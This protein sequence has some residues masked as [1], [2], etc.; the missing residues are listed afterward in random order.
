MMGL[1]SSGIITA[2]PPNNFAN[3]LWCYLIVLSKH[4]RCC[5]GIKGSF[6]SCKILRGYFHNVVTSSH[7]DSILH[8][9]LLCPRVK[10]TDTMPQETRWGMQDTQSLVRGSMR[11]RIRKDMGVEPLLVN[12]KHAISCGNIPCSRPWPAAIFPVMARTGSL[13]VYGAPE[14]LQHGHASMQSTGMAP[15][16]FCL[17]GM[18]SRDEGLLTC[19]TNTVILPTLTRSHGVVSFPHDE[20]VRALLVSQAL[21][22]LVFCPSSIAQRRGAP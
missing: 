14:T 17:V 5:P 12:T 21:A 19:C 13:F 16:C 18:F 11:N 3:S 4:P 15:A 22:G 20:V 1:E 8:V 2:L 6:D 9:L 7:N 10:V